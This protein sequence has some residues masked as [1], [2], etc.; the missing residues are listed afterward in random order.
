MPTIAPV[1]N[2]RCS[3]AVEE[4]PPL[5]L[6]SLG[7]ILFEL[8][9]LFPLSVGY[10]SR[11]E[12]GIKSSMDVVKIEGPNVGPSVG[13]I[14]RELPETVRVLKGTVSESEGNGALEMKVSVVRIADGL[15]VTIVVGGM[16]GSGE[17][18]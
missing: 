3:A 11:E 6:P 8:L 5:T 15:V 17:A 2:L 1:E 9:P 7:G 13:G 12:L 14:K 4:F 16:E 10:V 18:L